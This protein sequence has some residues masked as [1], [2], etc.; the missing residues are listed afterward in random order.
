MPTTK[1]IRNLPRM[2]EIISVAAKFGFGE[3]IRNTKL[4]T[5]LGKFKKLHAIDH[6]PAPVRF[7]LALE[8]LGPTFM[9]LGQVLSMRPRPCSAIVVRGIGK[10]TGQLPCCALGRDQG[11]TPK[12]IWGQNRLDV[13]FY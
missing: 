3:V 2:K 11:R 7:R 8:E 9:K 6:E 5:F 13:Y 4:V 12:G 1:L 10:L